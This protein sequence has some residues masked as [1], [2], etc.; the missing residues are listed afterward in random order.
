MSMVLRILTARTW[1]NEPCAICL[2]R[3][4]HDPAP[5]NR[6]RDSC[7]PIGV[8]PT[9]IWAAVF[10][11]LPVHCGDDWLILYRWII[12]NIMSADGP[13]RGSLLLLGRPE[14]MFFHYFFTWALF[15]LFPTRE[16]SSIKVHVLCKD[17]SIYMKN[18]W[19]WNYEM[20]MYL[21][22]DVRTWVM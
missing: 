1:I 6:S 11:T 3:S 10:R 2:I 16:T 14:S 17:S 5:R 21:G 8:V 19:H 9:D 18:T 20:D 13:P 12:L 22:V 7:D 4:S 15:I